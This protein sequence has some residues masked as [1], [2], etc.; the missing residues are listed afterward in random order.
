[1]IEGVPVPSID[2][3]SSLLIFIILPYVI[4]KIMIKIENS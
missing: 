3:L 1:M 4:A 2:P